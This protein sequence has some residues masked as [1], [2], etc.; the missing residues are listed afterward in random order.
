MPRSVSNLASVTASSRFETEPG[1]FASLRRSFGV[2]V[3]G[4]LG[5]FEIRIVSGFEVGAVQSLGFEARD[6]R[7]ARGV[8]L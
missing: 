5:C 2:L 7:S 1:G 3:F 6:G 4:R 8:K